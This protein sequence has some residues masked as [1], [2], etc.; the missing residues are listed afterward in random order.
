MG[1]R[2]QCVLHAPRHGTAP[3][4]S[5]LGFLSA[6]V[7]IWDLNCPTEIEESWVPHPLRDKLEVAGGLEEF[8]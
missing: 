2:R 4:R 5:E 8:R 7:G 6:E 1:S 3:P